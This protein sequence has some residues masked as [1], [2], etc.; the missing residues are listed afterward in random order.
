MITAFRLLRAAWALALIFAF[1]PASGVLGAESKAE[2]K[3]VA[4]GLF[5]DQSVFESEAK[6]AAQ[7]VASDFGG[8]PVIVRASTKRRGEATS[9]TVAATL[10]SAAEAMNVDNDILFLILTSHGSRAGLAVKTP[11]SQ[12]ILSPLDL[13]TMLDRMQVRHRIVIISACFSG[14]FIPPL[15]DPDTLGHHR[16]GCESPIVRLQERK[17]V[18]LFRGRLLQHGAASHRESEGCI[19]PGKLGRPQARAA[20]APRAVQ[21]AN[22]R[23]RKY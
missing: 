17:H 14:V 4:F 9:E 1:A 23:G 8:S 5:G 12:E 2:V 11:S 18:D 19:C 6:G 22:R 7:I 21:P 15:A 10:Q 16:G 20:R 13:F 3:V